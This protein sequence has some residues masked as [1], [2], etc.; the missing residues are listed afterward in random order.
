MPIKHSGKTPKEM[1]QELKKTLSVLPVLIGNEAVNFFQDNFKKEGFQG[2]SGLEKWPARSQNA[3]RNSG[4]ALLVNKGLLFKSIV[5]QV[6]PSNIR[7]FIVGPAAV[8]GGIHNSGGVTH[9]SVTVKSKA[10]AWN[11]YKATGKSVYKGM[12]MAKPGTRLNVV[13]PQRKFIG[14]SRQLDQ[15]IEAIII[16][17]LTKALQ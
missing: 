9:P 12:A 7:I 1:I 6:G 4:R 13:I 2:D 3:Q 8:Y 11:M 14:N 15:R 10:W 16:R 17:Q 5:K